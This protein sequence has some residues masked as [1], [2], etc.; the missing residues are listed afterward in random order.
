MNKISAK[1]LGQTKVVGIFR[2]NLAPIHLVHSELFSG[3][4]DIREK[5]HHRLGLIEN[6]CAFIFI[7]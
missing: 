6:F 4:C 1:T 2:Q 5:L 7:F 3:V